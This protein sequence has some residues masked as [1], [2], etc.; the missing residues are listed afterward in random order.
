MNLSTSYVVW[1]QLPL[2]PASNSNSKAIPNHSFVSEFS[3]LYRTEVQGNF[4]RSA[5]IEL[6][7]FEVGIAVLGLKGVTQA[8]WDKQ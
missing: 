3:I 4:N 8:Q 2:V 5:T 7:S 6:I 1:F